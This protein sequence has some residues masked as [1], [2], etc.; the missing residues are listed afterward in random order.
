MTAP[1]PEFLDEATIH[2]RC[3]IRWQAQT[4]PPRAQPARDGADDALAGA[5]HPERASL[6]EG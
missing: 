6:S 5:N 4:D 1:L 2:R 3:R